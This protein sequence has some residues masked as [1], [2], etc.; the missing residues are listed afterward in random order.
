MPALKI[1]EDLIETSYNAMI[2]QVMD[3]TKTALYYLDVLNIGELR[4]ILASEKIVITADR[5]NSI[6]IANENSDAIISVGL[7]NLPLTT[8]AS[9]IHW[10]SRHAVSHRIRYGKET[11]VL[12][13]NKEARDYIARLTVLAEITQ[14]LRGMVNLLYEVGEIRR[15]DADD[16]YTDALTRNCNPTDLQC[17]IRNALGLRGEVRERAVRAVERKVRAIRKLVQRHNFIVEHVRQLPLERVEWV[18]E[19]WIRDKNRMNE[20]F[21]IYPSYVEY[22]GEVARFVL[23]DTLL[24]P[25]VVMPVIT[26]VNPRFTR[27]VLNIVTLR[28]YMLNFTCEGS[29]MLGIDKT[30][31]QPFAIALPRNCLHMPIQVCEEYVMGLRNTRLRPT[32]NT[33]KNTIEIIEV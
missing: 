10:L 5:E 9:I 3:E 11:F 13:T 2:R 17:L 12:P 29:W 30:T 26:G 33:G 16:L 20:Y 22:D 21:R 14:N 18:N 19:G 6:T 23:S 28:K 25:V 4:K 15:S 7:G 1:S 31:N 24:K 8:I 32:T 27:F